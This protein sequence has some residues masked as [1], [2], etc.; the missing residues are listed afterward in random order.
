MENTYF[1]YL[2]T[3][4]IVGTVGGT[5]NLLKCIQC[6]SV[7]TDLTYLHHTS[8]PGHG[9]YY[10]VHAVYAVRAPEKTFGREQ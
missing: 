6:P 10:P 7:P 4:K 2:V 5:G 1:V 9:M 8:A 3:R